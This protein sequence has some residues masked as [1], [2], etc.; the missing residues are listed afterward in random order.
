MEMWSINQGQYSI[1]CKRWSVRRLHPNK[2]VVE[3]L[4]LHPLKKTH[5]HPRHQK[6]H[7][8]TKPQN[9]TLK[10]NPK[11]PKK[12]PTQGFPVSIFIHWIQEPH[13]E[14]TKNPCGFSPLLQEPNSVMSGGGSPPAPTTP[15]LLA[16][17]STWVV[18]QGLVILT[19]STARFFFST[20]AIWE[21][22]IWNSSMWRNCV[23][24][25]FLHSER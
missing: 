2:N 22:Q 1:D 8:K 7:F 20:E 9:N 13:P 18:H 16:P 17:T 15:W 11:P 3:T 19:A 4:N 5:Y 12:N 14:P 23:I 21:L 6:K 25:R 10:R 24:S